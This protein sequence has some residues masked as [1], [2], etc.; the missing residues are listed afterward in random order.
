MRGA[1]I[2]FSLSHFY[3]NREFL[4]DVVVSISMSEYCIVA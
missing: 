4:F 3:T 2:V 1:W